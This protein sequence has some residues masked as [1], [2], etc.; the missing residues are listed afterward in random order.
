MCEPLGMKRPTK[1]ITDLNAAELVDRLGVSRSYA[2]ELLRRL[3]RPSLDVAVRIER[4][5]GVPASAWMQ[6]AA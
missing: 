4:E 1:K 5:F 3:K 2:S 6:D